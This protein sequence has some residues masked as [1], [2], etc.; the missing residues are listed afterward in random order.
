MNNSI[1]SILFF[2]G[3]CFIFLHCNPPEPPAGPYFG[4]GVHNGWADQSS[5]LVWTRLT[6]NPE[7]NI[8]GEQ[9]LVHSKEE[10]KLLDEKGN[11][12]DI[13]HAQ[14]P[15]GLTLE[16]MLGAC[17]GKS[18]WGKEQKEWLFQTMQQSD[19]TFKVLISNDPILGPDRKNKKDNYSNS[20]WKYEGDEIR[21]FLNESGNVFICNGDRHWQY[22][23]HYEGTNLCEFSC[24]V[25]S[26]IH[27]GGWSAKDKRPNH[28]F[29]RILGG[30]LNLEVGERDGTPFITFKYYDVNGNVLHV[31]EFGT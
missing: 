23:T 4:N 13:H 7:G 30:C 27:A 24:S 17:P 28:R 16:Q 31:E 10:L 25:G 3:L 12:K 8:D 26:D 1:W 22:V 18:I 29:L 15:E 5:I 21:S 6:R 9:F 11:I 2:L 14:I 20:N 19:A